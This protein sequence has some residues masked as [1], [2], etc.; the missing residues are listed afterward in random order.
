MHGARARL[1]DKAGEH[2]QRIACH[3][4]QHAAK[5][6]FQCG[7]GMVKPPAVGSAYT[8]LSGRAVIEDEDGQ[9]VAGRSSGAE[10]R[11]VGEPQIL[12]EPADG[13]RSRHNSPSRRDAIIPAYWRKRLPLLCENGLVPSFSRTPVTS[14]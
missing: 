10:R 3:D 4:M 2:L 12:A 8:V 5:R 6:L 7:Q 14:R 11:I 13:E 9:H 1:G